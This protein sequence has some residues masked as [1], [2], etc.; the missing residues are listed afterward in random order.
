[1]FPLFLLFA[2]IQSL[3]FGYNMKPYEYKCFTDSLPHNELYQFKAIGSSALYILK[4]EYTEKMNN[5]IVYQREKVTSHF[6]HDMIV[7]YHYTVSFCFK[8]L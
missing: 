1:M 5:K 7:D 3:K 6:Y 8:N 4:I 2:T